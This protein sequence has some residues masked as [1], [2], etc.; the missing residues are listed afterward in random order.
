M[1]SLSFILKNESPLTLAQESLWR[2]CRNWRIRRLPERLAAN[3]PVVYRP[4]G[5]YK[6]NVAT[7]GDESKRLIL[8]YSR[9]LLDGRFSVFGYEDAQLGFPPAWNLDFVSGAAW[10]PAPSADM[11]VL[12]FDGSDVKVPWELSRLQFLPVLGKAWVL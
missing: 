4:V 5:L 12:R 8:E 1:R 10:P 9:R 3:C 2:A 7:M 11:N 6:P